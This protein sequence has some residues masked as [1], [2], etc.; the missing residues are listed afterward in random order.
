MRH[1]TILPAMDFIVLI[2]GEIARTIVKDVPVYFVEHL[3]G[4]YAHYSL[5]NNYIECVYDLSDLNKTFVLIHEYT[6]ALLTLSGAIEFIMLPEW[7]QQFINYC[8]GH[9]NGVNS[10]FWQEAICDYVAWTFVH[11]HNGDFEPID[12]FEQYIN[13]L[14]CTL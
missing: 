11:L 3:Q 2:F 1:N 9:K 7:E 14:R 8:N 10:N 5:T 6:H 13:M 4:V 12:A